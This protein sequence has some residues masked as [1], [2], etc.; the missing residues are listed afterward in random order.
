VSATCMVG[1]E[2]GIRRQRQEGVTCE[3]RRREEASKR[4]RE[5]AETRV[6][7][8]VTHSDPTIHT[9]AQHTLAAVHALAFSLFLGPTGPSCFSTSC[10]CLPPP[11]PP[12]HR[13]THKRNTK[14][15]PIQALLFRPRCP[16]ASFLSA[17]VIHTYPS[18]FLTPTTTTT[19]TTGNACTDEPCCSPPPRPRQP[20]AIFG[21]VRAAT[22]CRPLPALHPPTLSPF[23]TTLPSPAPTSRPSTP[24]APPCA[25][26][27]STF[28]AARATLLEPP[29]P[30]L[31]A[32][33]VIP[34][35]QI[36]PTAGATP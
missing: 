28:C 14:S 34:S 9:Q 4:R 17:F 8:S 3:A 31:P 13:K 20:A 30:L 26:S 35:S 22:T 6:F 15:G 11:S 23:R 16:Q 2:R 29:L 12:S 33:G 1:D 21:T 25:N 7:P 32:N 24:S 19:T 36:Y 10:L 18:P 5:G 27:I